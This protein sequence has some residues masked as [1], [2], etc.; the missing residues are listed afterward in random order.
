MKILNYK[1]EKNNL[2]KNYPSLK[3]ALQVLVISQY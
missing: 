2:F 3:T 1:V